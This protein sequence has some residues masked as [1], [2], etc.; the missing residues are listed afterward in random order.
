[1]QREDYLVRVWYYHILHNLV[2]ILML[3]L[4]VEERIPELERDIVL[5][6][7]SEELAQRKY[8]LC[9]ELVQ[10]KGIVVEE[11][12]STLN[13][14][15]SIL[16]D[17]SQRD[18][19]IEVEINDA[20]R[21]VVQLEKEFTAAVNIVGSRREE[22]GDILEGLN[23]IR[24]KKRECEEELNALY[25]E[26][27]ALSYNVPAAVVSWKLP[28]E[29]EQQDMDELRASP[30]GSTQ[31]LLR[32][33]ANKIPRTMTQAEQ[34]RTKPASLLT[35][36]ERR[37]RKFDKILNPSKWLQLAYTGHSAAAAAEHAAGK[38]RVMSIDETLENVADGNSI[39]DVLTRK[40]LARIMTVPTEDLIREEL[41]IRRIL[42]LFNDKAATI[43]SDGM[44][45]S[46]VARYK[47][48]IDRTPEEREFVKLDAV[49]FP[50][51]YD[52]K[53]ILREDNASKFSKDQITKIRRTE[54]RLL[55]DPEE[56][57][58]REILDKYLPQQSNA[59]GSIQKGTTEYQK[60]VKID[61]T[62]APPKIEFDVDQRC[63]E[64]LVELERAMKCL[65]KE[66]D[67]HILHGQ[68]QRFPTEVLRRELSR[69][70]DEMLIKQICEREKLIQRK[71]ARLKKEATPEDEQRE[72]ERVESEKK[73]KNSEIVFTTAPKPVEDAIEDLL[74]E[75]I[76]N[77]TKARQM[78]SGENK[79]LET[80][81][82]L[83]AQT[84]GV[85]AAKVK[86]AKGKQDSS[87]SDQQ[88]AAT[89]MPKTTKLQARRLRRAMSAA[90]EGLNEV[91][92]CRACK[93]A[94]C[95]WK[96]PYD[97]DV[98]V[99]R[100]EEV[101]R[102]LDAIRATSAVSLFVGNSTRCN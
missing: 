64:V 13:E 49:L 21:F 16:S 66:M 90:G 99:A 11:L 97:M 88:Q 26:L 89:N 53:R 22:Q 82:M 18:E 74:K 28:K 54:L 17:P 100:E 50:G 20:L 30:R 98:L 32:A 65:K 1:M 93:T 92:M 62:I 102:E 41:E 15:R 24:D 60:F 81:A 71:H 91:N 78:A 12:E 73:K 83:K 40:D 58:V 36:E 95:E 6:S 31:W 85:N 37:W 86:M 96:P 101:E 67:S 14:L 46:T 57:R 69:L 68:N 38:E 48:P 75:R 19:L 29:I 5:I 27:A 55:V 7:Q 47:N 79:A 56:M 52:G 25:K 80:V 77:P 34:I 84:G 35:Y 94:P 39:D 43:S 76:N 10:E 3:F 59:S 4:V 61:M 2:L 33:I 42:H 72:Q 45:I 51:Q 9:L 87:N 23:R 8:H 70:L 44:D 63:R